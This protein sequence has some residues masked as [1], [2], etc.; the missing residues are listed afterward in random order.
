M[1]PSDNHNNKKLNLIAIYIW[2]NSSM[3]DIK[4]LI[5]KALLPLSTVG[6][7]AFADIIGEPVE[8]SEQPVL[9][10][11]DFIVNFSLPEAELLLAFLR[12]KFSLEMINGRND[13][14]TKGGTTIDAVFARNIDKIDISIRQNPE[15]IIDLDFGL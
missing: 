3:R 15:M 11:G 13:P 2:P 12:E 5:G 1:N 9:L 7:Q 10:A 8:Y 4:L 14:T 6:S